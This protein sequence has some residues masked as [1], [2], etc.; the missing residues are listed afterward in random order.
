MFRIQNTSD[1][2]AFTKAY[3]AV[4][5]LYVEIYKLRSALGWTVGRFNSVL[6][7]LVDQ[8]VILLQLGDPS[9]LTED[10]KKILIWMAGI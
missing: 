10:Q 5:R 9:A 8:V 6:K 3:Q 1:I 7:D 4:G 2:E